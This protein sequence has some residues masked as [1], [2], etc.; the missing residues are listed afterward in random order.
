MSSLFRILS[1][2]QEYLE[3]ATKKRKKKIIS[4]PVDSRSGDLAKFDNF[5]AFYA[6]L[7]FS[8]R[9]PPARKTLSRFIVYR[10][11]RNAKWMS[12]NRRGSNVIAYANLTSIWKSILW[13]LRKGIRVKHDCQPAGRLNKESC[14]WPFKLL[15]LLLTIPR[16]RARHWYVNYGSSL[17]SD[18]IG[19]HVNRRNDP[20]YATLLPSDC[21][22]TFYFWRYV[23]QRF[24]W[25]RILPSKAS[26]GLYVIHYI[27]VFF[28]VHKSC[29]SSPDN[30][31]PKARV[32]FQLQLC[33]RGK[34]KAAKRRALSRVIYMLLISRFVIFIYVL[35]GLW[36]GHSMI[37]K[38]LY[39]R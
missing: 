31:I 17:I 5:C 20:N 13:I 24:R 39:V 34:K 14:A 21:R 25:L 2:A 16:V 30:V 7:N 35:R 37:I 3:I 1:R 32:C 28:S 19:Y 23:I 33:G 6:S 38:D 10:W 36:R 27:W 26:R 12:F 11:P 18:L 22:P 4:N 8:L 15:E 9:F 29:P